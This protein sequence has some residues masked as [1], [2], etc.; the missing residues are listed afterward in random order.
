MPK[1]D[2]IIPVSDFRKDA[3]SILDG[4][5]NSQEP[6]VITRR[7]RPAA[8]LQKMEDYEKQQHDLELLLQLVEGAADITA[9]RG[10]PMDEVMSEVRALIDKK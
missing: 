9:G 1:I 7:G 5:C 8:V 4:L 3:A 2:K 6:Y 10:Y